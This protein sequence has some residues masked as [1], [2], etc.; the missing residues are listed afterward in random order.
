VKIRVALHHHLPVR[1]IDGQ[2][3]G[4]GSYRVPVEC[5]V[6]V[7]HAGL[8]IKGIDLG[9]NGCEKRHCQPVQELRVLAMDADTVAVAIQFLHAFQ[10]VTGQIQVLALLPAQIRPG[11]LQRGGILFQA[12]DILVHQ[13]EDG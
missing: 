7:G 4:A 8:C 9:R 3:V 12:D 5:D 6:A 11:L 2:H 10:R 13:A 1:V